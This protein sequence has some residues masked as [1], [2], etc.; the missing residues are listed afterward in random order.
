MFSFRS[1]MRQ[2]AAALLAAAAVVPAHAVVIDTGSYANSGMGAEFASAYDNF[3]ITG[4]PNAYHFGVLRAELTMED[5]EDFK[6]YR[7]PEGNP[8][9]SRLRYGRYRAIP[10]PREIVRIATPA[11]IC[12]LLS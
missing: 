8:R 3:S 1:L 10:R 11:D 9:Q 6:V 7:R 5:P 2:T 4:V 12:A